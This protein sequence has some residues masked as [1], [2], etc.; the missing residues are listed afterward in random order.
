MLS[1]F[2]QNNRIIPMIGSSRIWYTGVIRTPE[3]ARTWGVTTTPAGSE[4]YGSTWDMVAP[5]FMVDDDGTVWI[6]VSF[7]YYASW[8]NDSSQNDIMRPYLIK[9][10]GL[11]PGADPASDPGAQPIVSYSN[12]VPINLPQYDS[13]HTVT[14]RI[15]GSLYKRGN[16]YY[17]SVKKDG[18][19]NEIWRTTNL[20][21]DAVQNTSNWELVTDDAVTGFEGPSLTKYNGTYYMYTDKLKDY[22]PEN[23]DGKAGVYVSVASTATTGALDSFLPDGW[24]RTSSRSLHTL[25]TAAQ[26][27][28]GT[29]LS[30]PS[31]TVMPSRRSGIA[32]H[33]QD[34]TIPPAPPTHRHL[35]LP[36]GTIKKASRQATTAVSSAITGM[37]GNVR[38]G[39]LL[40][41]ARRSMIQPAMHG[42]GWIPTQTAK[43]AVSKD[44]YQPYTIQGQDEIGKWVR[45]DEYGHMIKE[46]GS[47]SSYRGHCR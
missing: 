2:S 11:K 3:A 43:M 33:R 13:S 22:P 46:R 25:Q 18:V 45:Y 8:H 36:A 34:T 26:R 6:V 38:Q 12:A 5:D 14:N 27:N 23:A 1:G 17:F 44:V 39:V 9:A 42:T 47:S 16:Y 24:S 20:S 31:K 4:K 21:L 7:G 40:D 19:T 29:V 15:D 28:V 37:R 10:T 35:L 30:L 41:A 32:V